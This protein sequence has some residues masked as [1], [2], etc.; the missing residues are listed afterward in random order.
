MATF[1]TRGQARRLQ[2]CVPALLIFC[3]LITAATPA[4]AQQTALEPGVAEA[5]SNRAQV[6]F[7]GTLV[8][9]ADGRLTVT[10]NVV[11]T[12]G[13][14]TIRADEMV[15]EPGGE[16]AHFTGNVLVATPE[17]EFT[18]T[19]FVYDMPAGTSVLFQPRGILEVESVEGPVYFKGETMAVEQDRVIL[20]GAMFTTCSCEKSG[21]YLAGTRMEIIPDV[22]MVI[23]NVRFV[24]SGITL[25]Y[26]PKLTIPLNESS[27]SPFRLPQIGHSDIDG[28]FVKVAFPYAGIGAGGL[29]L[30]DWFQYKGIGAGVTH[31]YR[32]DASGMGQVHLY[33]LFN[34]ITGTID[35]VVEWAGRSTGGGWSTSWE[36]SYSEEG[37]PYF[38]KQ[39]TSASLSVQNTR[40]DGQ[41]AVNGS[42]ARDTTPTTTHDRL[43]GNLRLTQNLPGN[44]RLTVSGDTLIR[45]GAPPERRL[46]GYRVDL[47]N[48]SGPVTWSVVVDQRYHPDLA[49]EEQTGM[50]AWTTSGRKPEITVATRPDVTLLGRTFPL[51]FE[52]GYGVFGER[53]AL[54]TVEETRRTALA[55]LRTMTVPLGSKL[56][57]SLGGSARGYWYGDGSDRLVLNASTAAT[58]RPVAGVTVRGTYEYQG[59]RGQTPFQFDRVTPY[60]RVRGSIQYSGDLLDVTVGSGYDL[61]TERPM[62]VTLDLDTS[63]LPYTSIR[64]RG[65]YNL[66]DQAPESVAAALELGDEKTVSVKV[67]G[68]YVFGTAD[69][70]RIDAA[71][72]LQLGT[73]SVGYEAIYDGKNDKFDRGALTLLRDLD[74]RVIG[75]SYDQVKGEVWLEYRITA[76][77]NMGLRLGSDEQRLMFD[78]EGWEELFEQ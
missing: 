14:L 74:C 55:Q 11:F 20:T 73:W 64:L 56:S 60:E 36:A 7:D 6:E 9:D 21:Y 43:S 41:I 18:G 8:G 62:N 3:L 71:L 53:R 51:A 38:R 68:K 33:G 42:V 69:F 24:E 75:I 22:R 10:G 25:F 19:R 37:W 34:R 39:H 40:P 70:E 32:D 27:R 65:V 77:P 50:P 61:R 28:W 54:E 15:V 35:P 1:L 44:T 48:T 59:D 76:I 29:L 63:A 17:Q 23:Y 13:D 46:F 45:R 12:Y 78:L 66:A 57:L 16:V 72:R 67:G 2:G 49:K 4:A 47:G 58:Y 52:V 26:W 31:Y 5:E 30:L